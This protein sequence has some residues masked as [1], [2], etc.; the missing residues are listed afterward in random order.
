MAQVIKDQVPSGE[1]GGYAEGR[2]S[3]MSL[4]Q[5]QCA[6]TDSCYKALNVVWKYFIWKMYIKSY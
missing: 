5:E 6:D 4:D 1:A 3:A 2:V